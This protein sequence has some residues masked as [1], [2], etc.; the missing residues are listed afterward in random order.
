LKNLSQ[1]SIP[2]PH[3]M[4]V[5]V[6]LPSS[7]K[8][9]CHPRFSEAQETTESITGVILLSELTLFFVCVYLSLPPNLLK[10][11]RQTVNTFKL[12]SDAPHLYKL[13]KHP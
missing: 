4:W 13:Q 2:L 1:H 11:K 8:V 7:I 12:S 3:F 10:G 6:A 5:G 9:I